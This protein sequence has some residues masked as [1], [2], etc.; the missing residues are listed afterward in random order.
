MIHFPSFLKYSS[1][2]WKKEDIS[3]QKSCLL[4]V[5]PCICCDTGQVTKTLGRPRRLNPG[6]HASKGTRTSRTRVPR[7]LTF[8]SPSEWKN[9]SCAGTAGPKEQRRAD[10]SLLAVLTAERCSSQQLFAGI[11]KQGMR[12]RFG[13]PKLHESLN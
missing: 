3:Q 5:Q 9:I 1:R 2:K 7:A 6:P 12:E 4:H 10:F 13:K 8:A 11:G